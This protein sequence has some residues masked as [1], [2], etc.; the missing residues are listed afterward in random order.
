MKI[1]WPKLMRKTHYWGSII[2][3][4][5][6]II[7][8]VTG[9]ILLFKKDINW[10]QPSSAKGP[11]GA[12]EISFEQVLESA[13][14]VSEAGIKGWG[15]INRL[16]VRPSKGIIK[17]RARN[18]WEIQID[19]KTGEVIQV[20]FRRSDIIESIHDGSFF[21]DSAKLWLFLPSS[22]ILLFLWFSGIYLFILPFLNKN[23]RK[24]ALASKEN[25][26]VSISQ[27]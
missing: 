7:V 13:K 21:H 14:T 6:V 3:S 20:A 11:K 15:D 25:S 4:I 18:N 12:P 17:I 2:C 24:K 1:K 16:D 19:Q 8:L 22:L 26:S 5:P 23:K 9:I 27:K 10:I